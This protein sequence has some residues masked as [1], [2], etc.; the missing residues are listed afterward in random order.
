M[1]QPKKPK[2]GADAPHPKG[3]LVTISDIERARCRDRRVFLGLRQEDL[4]TRVGVTTA[5]ISN[6]ESGRSR[7]IRKTVYA[8]IKRTLRVSDDTS[9]PNDDEFARVV[10]DLIDLDARG[11]RAVVALIDSLKKPQ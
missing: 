2:G 4:A 9:A 5:T 1:T 8:K 10:E 3:A 7:Q 6:F 11:M